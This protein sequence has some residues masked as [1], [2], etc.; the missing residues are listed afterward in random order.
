MEVARN[1]VYVMSQGAYVHRDGENLLVDVEKVT[2]LRQP[3]HLVDALVCFGRIT[4]SPPAMAFCAERGIAVTFLSRSGRLLARVDAPGSGNVLVRREQYRRADQ[5]AAAQAIAKPIVAGKIHNARTV[6]QRA[7]RESESEEDRVN[8]SRVVSSL[9]RTLH[10]L[11]DAPDL[12]SVR[13]HEGEAAQ[14]YYGTFTFMVKQQR[15]DFAFVR[16][17]RRPPR[18]RI[19]ALLSFVYSLLLSDTTAACAAAGLDPSVGFLHADRPGRPGLALDLM[20]EFRPSIADRLAL[21]LINRQ[22]ITKK[23]FEERDG[24]T[25]WLNDS[26]R[27]TLLDAYQRRKHEKVSHP[28]LEQALPLRIFPAVQARLLARVLRAESETYVPCCFK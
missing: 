2:R 8:L 12:D 22:Q 11:A 21:T 27:R 10:R 28:V 4:V 7:A 15:E 25:V 23:D 16:R 1:V 5:P 26:G 19:N 9:E 24:G 3:I 17:S 6:V 13:G 18:D 14:A 20:E